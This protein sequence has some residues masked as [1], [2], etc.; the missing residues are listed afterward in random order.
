[1]NKTALALVAV[2]FLA[3]AGG[4]LAAMKFAPGIGAGVPEKGLVGV[5]RPDFNHRDIDGRPV[6]AA[7]FEGKALL[8]NFW[9]TWCAPC[10]EEMPMLSGLQQEWSSRGLQVIGI[11]LDDPER[12]AGFAAD[13]QLAYPVLIGGADVVV[14]GKRYG[15]DTGMLPFS[16]LTDRNG[17]IRWSHLG[18]LDPD[19]LGREIQAIL[20]PN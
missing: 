8:I 18:A 11:A 3:A 7:D 10:V 6:S 17:V 13:M 14:T 9:A 19:T 12:A 20:A 15:N 2:A 5:L 4:Y 16:V 1:M